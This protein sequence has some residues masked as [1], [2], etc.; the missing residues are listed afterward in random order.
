MTPANR[1]RAPSR[2]LELVVQRALSITGRVVDAEGRGVAA[3]GVFVWFADAPVPATHLA[4]ADGSFAIDVPPDFV[5]KLTAKA[6]DPTLGK[7]AAERVA[8]GTRD[9]VLHLR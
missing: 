7:A 4:A 1:I 3:A 6:V 2:N 5:G 8:A 9:L